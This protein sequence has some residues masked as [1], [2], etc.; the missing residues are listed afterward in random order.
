MWKD[1]NDTAQDCRLEQ[2][3]P[4]PRQY[5]IR[6][7]SEA[8]ILS[9]MFSYQ[10][11]TETTIPKFQAINQAAKNFAEVVL[12]HCPPSPDRSV[13]ILKIREARMTANQAIA[14]NGLSL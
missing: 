3:E 1:R 4:D 2:A 12:Q 9:R 6:A 11:P 10:P 7:E 13:V 5:G 8:E 14:C